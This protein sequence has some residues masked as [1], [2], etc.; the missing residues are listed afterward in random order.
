[1]E[2]LF[3]QFGDTSPT[4]VAVLIFLAV[5]PTMF[6]IMAFVRARGVIRRRALGAGGI[7]A[8]ATGARSLRGSSVKAANRLLDYAEKHYATGNSEQM[9][10]LRR[11]MFQA[12][13]YDPRAVAFFFLSRAVLAFAFAGA[14]FVFGPATPGSTAQWLF[15]MVGGIVGYIAPSF[16][17]DRRI[18]ARKQEHQA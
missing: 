4:L 12:G 5:S 17:I 8:G 11:R 18:K 1:M 9:K 13:I 14:V 3:G 6:G 15:V 16:Y 10:V 7:V 2:T